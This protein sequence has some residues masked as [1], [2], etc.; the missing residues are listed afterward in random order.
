[1]GLGIIIRKLNVSRLVFVVE[2][3]NSTYLTLA[4]QPV[5]LINRKSDI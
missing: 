3:F 2:I 5:C 1:M 4:N